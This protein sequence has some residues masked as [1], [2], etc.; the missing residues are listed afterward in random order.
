MRSKRVKGP[1]PRFA[2][3]RTNPL[4]RSP[5][6]VEQ[7][8][9]QSKYYRQERARWCELYPSVKRTARLRQQIIRPNIVSASPDVR[10]VGVYNANFG[11]PPIRVPHEER[12]TLIDVRDNIRHGQLGR[13]PCRRISNM[14][15]MFMP[16]TIV[17]E[18]DTG[19]LIVSH[20]KGSLK[21]RL[22]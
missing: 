7:F 15:D 19:D 2:A 6:N 8:A 13:T 4:T 5:L 18:I 21:E 10:R 17:G 22:R 20:F 14:S 16:S 12:V 11:A 1:S 3:G 9:E